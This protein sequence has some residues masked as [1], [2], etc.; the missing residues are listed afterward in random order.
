MCSI[1]MAGK[2]KAGNKP[3]NVEMLMTTWKGPKTELQYIWRVYPKTIS[4]PDCFFRSSPSPFTDKFKSSS[5][6]LHKELPRKT[7]FLWKSVPSFVLAWNEFAILLGSVL[8]FIQGI[9]APGC[10]RHTVTV[11]LCST[12]A[13]EDTLY[14]VMQ[15]AS[16]I[17]WMR[18]QKNTI[19]LGTELC[20]F[21][22]N[23]F[24]VT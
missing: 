12:E 11:P 24:S 4:W 20:R 17:A 19:P 15:S 3:L 2:N 16:D 22:K 8:K 6:C 23:K 13:W 21:S 9:Q 7:L 5:L 18:N 1:A 14:R 10:G